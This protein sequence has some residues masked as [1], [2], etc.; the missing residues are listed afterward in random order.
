MIL[1]GLGANLAFEDRSPVQNME[2]VLERLDASASVSIEQISPWYHTAPV[3]E[4]DQPDYFNG[5]AAL[6]TSL[7]PLGLMGLLLE[8][9]RRFGRIRG[10]RWGPRTMDLDL[11]DFEG[12]VL[13][14]EEGGVTLHLP[15]PRLHERAFVLFPLMDVAPDWRHPVSK[16]GATQYLADISPD[17]VVRKISDTG[18]TG[19]DRA[20][21]ATKGRTGPRP[22]KSP[23][24]F[25]G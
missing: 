24:P 6:T 7:D 16:R 25:T 18:Q 21:S 12:K 8:T 5:V 23:V 4:M 20:G 1:I 15:H 11:L 3:G 13:D 17:Q 9:E 19:A 14:L 2:R 10:E 22:G